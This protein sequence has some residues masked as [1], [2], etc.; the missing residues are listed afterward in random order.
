M[1]I[2]G[3]Y[4]CR[5]KDARMMSNPLKSSNRYIIPSH[6]R[7]LESESHPKFFSYLLM[8]VAVKVSSKSVTRLLR[9][10]Q[11]FLCVPYSAADHSLI[12]FHIETV[13]IL[14]SSDSSDKLV[15]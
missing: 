10:V 3:L 9:A 14:I 11:C 15:A 2:R 8:F 4:V 6:M 5:C 7:C 13:T 12:S 1:L